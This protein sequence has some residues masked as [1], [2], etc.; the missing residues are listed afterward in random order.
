MGDWLGHFALRA[1]ARTGLG[2]QPIVWFL[3]TAL[4]LALPP[5]RL[6]QAWRLDPL[7][8]AVQPVLSDVASAGFRRA[9]R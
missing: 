4:S 2:A 3:I 1:Q 6:L 5:G 9:Q 7:S 8:G